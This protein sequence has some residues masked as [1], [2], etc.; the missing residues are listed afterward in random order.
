ML[1]TGGAILKSLSVI[2]AKS[3]AA[4]YATRFPANRVAEFFLQ[5]VQQIGR[6]AT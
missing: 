5:T 6:A 2:F 4:V 1:P 3:Y